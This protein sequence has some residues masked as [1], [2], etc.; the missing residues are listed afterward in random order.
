[1]LAGSG[2]ALHNMRSCLDSIA[3]ELAR[4]HLGGNMT[5]DQEWAV[6]FP[7]CETAAQFDAFL[8]KHGRTHMYGPADREALRCA[9]PFDLREQA[10]V[11]GVDFATS[12]AEE[13]RINQLARLSRLNNLDKHRYLPL[14]AWYFDIAYFTD[15]VP[16]GQLTVRRHVPLNDGE[17]I[18]HLTFEETAAGPLEKLVVRMGLT[19]ADD[20]GCATD[21]L[22]ALMDWHRY[23]TS[24]ILPR[25]F[26]VAAGN[27]PPVGFL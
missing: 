18:G 10:A 17:L 16:P 13:Y 12:P 4:R 19:F 8:Q 22:G 6:K 24:W 26:I 2:D 5:G 23:L 21:F 14:L 7:I 25:I 15:M 27:P 20:P 11:V 1:M 3:Y 9:Q